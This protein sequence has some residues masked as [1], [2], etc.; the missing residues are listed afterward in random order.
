MN[1]QIYVYV[2]SNRFLPF[3]SPGVSFQ[4]L[5]CTGVVLVGLFITIEP[6]IWNLEGSGSSSG[7]GGGTGVGRVL[8]PMCFALG[9]VP[10][11]LLNVY[12]ERQT[13]SEEVSLV[14][15]NRYQQR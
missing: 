2:Y 3:Y 10:A 7:N 5:V 9:F 13:K 15:L 1:A 8:W 4:R 14:Y 6:Q 12:I 11:A